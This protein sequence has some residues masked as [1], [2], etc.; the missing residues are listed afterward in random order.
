MTSYMGSTHASLRTAVPYHQMCHVKA[1][2]MYQDS[3]IRFHDWFKTLSSWT[4]LIFFSI[5]FVCLTEKQGGTPHPTGEP[6]YPRSQKSDS[7]RSSKVQ[8]AFRVRSNE[9]TQIMVQ[10][11]EDRPLANSIMKNQPDRLKTNGRNMTSQQRFRTSKH[12]CKI[13]LF[14]SKRQT[15]VETMRPRKEKTPLLTCKLRKLLHCDMLLAR[16]DRFQAT[17]STLLHVVRCHNQKWI[18]SDW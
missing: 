13:C 4:S 16:C 6:C 12:Q 15:E 5:G 17:P 7:V 18:Y 1:D 14:F 8:N 2:R 11:S 10:P 9:A 3:M